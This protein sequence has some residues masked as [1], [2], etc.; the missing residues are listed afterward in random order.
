MVKSEQEASTLRDTFG[1][2]SGTVTTLLSSVHTPCQKKA[3]LGALRILH[4]N[5]SVFKE[6]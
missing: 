5:V 4:A 6:A 3:I 2:V 1:A